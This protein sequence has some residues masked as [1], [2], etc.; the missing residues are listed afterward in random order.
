MNPIPAW[1]A[2]QAADVQAEL[3]NL[4]SYNPEPE[5]VLALVDLMPLVPHAGL[6]DLYYDVFYCCR[7]VFRI[8][9]EQ[10]HRPDELSDFLRL[11][12]RA[13]VDAADVEAF[14]AQCATPDD[15][16]EVIFWLKRYLAVRT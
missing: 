10:L 2:N 1:L 13:I 11:A 8:A 6:V 14:R 9:V 16:D 12:E 15:V 4:L 5:F 7:P 3:N